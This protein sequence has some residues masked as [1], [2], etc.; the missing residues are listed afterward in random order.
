MLRSLLTLVLL[1][2]Q[3]SFALAQGH[4][5]TKQEQQACSRDASRF[6]RKQ[7]GDDG[8]VQQCLQQHR[9]KLSA[10]CRQVFQS[11]GM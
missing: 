11:H 5:G 4:A 9:N 3:L 6:C 2:F 8:A 1:F 7:L 10:A